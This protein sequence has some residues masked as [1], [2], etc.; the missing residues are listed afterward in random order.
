[1]EQKIINNEI[2]EIPCPNCNGEGGWDIAIPSS[3]ENFTWVSDGEYLEVAFKKCFFCDDGM[4]SDEKF[5]DYN[6]VKKL[7]E[8]NRKK[9]KCE[10]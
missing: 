5:K 9:Y 4:L 1:M 7:K 3:F 2:T 10:F 8:K 6:R